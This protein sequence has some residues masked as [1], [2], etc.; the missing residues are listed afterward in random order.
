MNKLLL[1]VVAL[2]AR[3]FGPVVAAALLKAGR[4]WLSD[5]ANEP[6]RAA[7]LAQLR[8]ISDRAGGS[9][10]RL[11]GGL[12]RQVEARRRGVGPWEREMMSLRYEVADLPSGEVRAAAFGAYLVQIAWAAEVVTHA[13][14]PAEARRQVLAGLENEARAVRAEAFGPDERRRALEALE[15]ARVACYRQG[16]GTSA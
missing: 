2:V 3:R 15:D 4:T 11:A 7:L 8:G 10:S 6:A 12:A 13:G 1:S 9:A 16:P 14:R 5:P